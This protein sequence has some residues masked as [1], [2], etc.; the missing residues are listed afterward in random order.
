[1]IDVKNEKIALA[2][3]CRGIPEHISTK[4][5]LRQYLKENKDCPDCMVYKL[6]GGEFE[7]IELPYTGK[8]YNRS[9]INER[10]KWTYIFKDFVVAK[11][12]EYGKYIDITRDDMTA[13]KQLIE[14]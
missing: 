10:K 3:Y 8:A 1:M 9:V 5:N 6:Y 12:N 4:Y 2:I 14:Y 7:V 11:K 13:L